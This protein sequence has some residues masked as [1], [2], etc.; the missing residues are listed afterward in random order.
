VVCPNPKREQGV[1]WRSLRNIPVTGE[2]KI[3]NAVPRLPEVCVFHV[4]EMR[5]LVTIVA[6][7]V[8][9]KTNISWVVSTLI[10]QGVT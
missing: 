6:T 3:S 7:I 9:G 1:V 4:R 8:T 2:A 10:W 5:Y